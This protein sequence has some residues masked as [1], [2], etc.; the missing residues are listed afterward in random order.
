MNNRSMIY[1]Q[2]QKKV[3]GCVVLKDEGH[4]LV[5]YS[6]N[7]QKVKEA[8]LDE[9]HAI[10]K[11]L[12]KTKFKKVILFLNNIDVWRMIVGITK[13]RG[14]RKK[15]VEKI[16]KLRKKIDVIVSWHEAYLFEHC[17]ALARSIV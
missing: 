7:V 13:V 17:N 3:I 10:L 5:S 16:N 4:R 9:I 8:Y 12:I 6:R 15:M 11:V 1:I 14:Y 2:H